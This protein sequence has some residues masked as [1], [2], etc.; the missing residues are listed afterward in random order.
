M[1][2]TNFLENELLDHVFGNSAYGAPGNLHIALSTTPPN[3]DGTNFTEPVGGAYVRVST[4]NNL[5][6][7]PAAVAG[8]K[9]NGTAIAFPEA[10]LNWGTITH[11]GI[12]DAGVGGNL[13]GKGALTVSR[14]IE[15]GDVAQF[16][17]GQIAITLD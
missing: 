16:N 5:T 12:Y 17:I 3:D 1:S 15:I 6:N 2:F 14:T 10:T 7:W 4:V 11:F 13:L 8:S 9:S